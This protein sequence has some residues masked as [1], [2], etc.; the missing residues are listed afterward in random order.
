MPDPGLLASLLAFTLA[1]AI[2]PGPNNLLLMSSGALF[3]WRAT[4]P[5]F[6]GVQIGFAF[7]C[8]SAVLGIGAVLE[9]WPWLFTIIRFAGASWLTWMALRYLR[10]AWA[11]SRTSGRVEAPATLSN[12]SSN[13]P[14]LPSRPF[15]FHEAVLM[16]GV[17]P[18]AILISL[19]TAAAF[20]DVSEHLW[21][22]T[23]I[24]G[25][26]YMV[27]GI[28][29]GSVWLTLGQLVNRAMSTGPSAVLI[30]VV[31]A[32]LL[33]GTALYIAFG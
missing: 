20:V 19:S 2:T 1:G 15:R 4:L 14:P 6:A 32:L 22:R 27:T 3:G 33:L 21:E 25:S 13:P 28:F 11:V 16:Q 10:L 29:A 31:M 12:Q 8:A 17:N 23:I 5:H 18:K 7:V 24:I 30:N 26:A 9:S